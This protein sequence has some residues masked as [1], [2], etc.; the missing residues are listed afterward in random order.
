MSAAEKSNDFKPDVT[1]SMAGEMPLTLLA[2]APLQR[3]AGAG[4]FQGKATAVTRDSLMAEAV[5]LFFCV[6]RFLCFRL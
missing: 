5:Q 4:E 3:L 1:F 6:W 2:S